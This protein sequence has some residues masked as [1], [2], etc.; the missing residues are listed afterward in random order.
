MKQA[1]GNQ[2]EIVT[3][4]AYTVLYNNY[5]YQLLYFAKSY[6][7]SIACNK[8]FIMS[9]ITEYAYTHK[10]KYSH[11]YSELLYEG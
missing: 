10:R 5:N 7:G 8:M 3:C 9:T 4:T 11:I 1:E 6:M 2:L